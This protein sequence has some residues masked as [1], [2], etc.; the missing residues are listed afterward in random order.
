MSNLL[1][2][3]S[4]AAQG[5]LLWHLWG[6]GEGTEQRCRNP[7]LPSCQSA[8]FPAQTGCLACGHC[9]GLPGCLACG[10]S[11]LSLHCLQRLLAPVSDCH[12]LCSFCG[13]T[14]CNTST[15]LCSRQRLD[16]FHCVCAGGLTTTKIRQQCACLYQSTG[17]QVMYRL[18]RLKLV[19]RNGRQTAAQPLEHT[20]PLCMSLY[21]SAIAGKDYPSAVII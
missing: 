21:G 17:K 14:F 1:N 8:C 10:C 7:A 12:F 19:V 6:L 13:C 2:T 11:A 18:K 4:K 3:N 20:L 15:F 16:A 5:Y 9:Q